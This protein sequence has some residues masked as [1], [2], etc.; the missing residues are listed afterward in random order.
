MLEITTKYFSLFFLFYRNSVAPI[1][2]SQSAQSLQTAPTE[3]Y[4][5][6]YNMNHNKRGLAV[7]FNHEFFTITHL[8]PRCGTNIDCENL[9]NTLKNLG[10]EVNDFHNLTHRDIVK[11]LERGKPI[12]ELHVHLSSY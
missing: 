10:F 12:F 5:T 4:A 1:G 2:I 9:V 7:I 11:N 8:K 3:R 6:H